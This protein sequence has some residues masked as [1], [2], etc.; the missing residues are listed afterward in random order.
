M[1]CQHY[2]EELPER[3]RGQYPP[4]STGFDMYP[5]YQG[6]FFMPLVPFEPPPY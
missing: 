2:I 3:K 4:D 5:V 1:D 6:D